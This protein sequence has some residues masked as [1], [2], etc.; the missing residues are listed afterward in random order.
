[1]GVFVDL[2]QMCAVDLGI[3]LGRRQT[4]MAEQFLDGTQIRT[5]TEKMRGEGMS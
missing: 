5:R 3:A 2:E 1:M 4:R